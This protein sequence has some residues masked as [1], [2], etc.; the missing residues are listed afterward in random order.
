[1]GEATHAL[2]TM[3]GDGVF[4]DTP[5][6]HQIGQVVVG[7]DDADRTGRSGGLGENRVGRIADAHRDVVASTGR[8]R[9]HADNNGNICLF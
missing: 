8:D 2:E 4:L 1:M 6:L 9:A 3:A 5:F 7:N